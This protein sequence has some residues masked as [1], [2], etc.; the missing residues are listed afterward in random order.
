MKLPMSLVA[1]PSAPPIA[2]VAESTSDPRSG[3]G[4]AVYENFSRGPENEKGKQDLPITATV[5]AKT[6]ARVEARMSVEDG[7]VG[8]RERPGIEIREKTDGRGREG[9]REERRKELH[10]NNLFF[11]VR[12]WAGGLPAICDLHKALPRFGTQEIILL[13]V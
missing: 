3:L 6:E 7:L 13:Q 5:S 10:K 12:G 2:A 9:R 1:F 4:A 8:M 11:S